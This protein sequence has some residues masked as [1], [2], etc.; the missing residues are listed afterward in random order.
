MAHV[1]LVVAVTAER[2]VLTCG[3]TLSWHAIHCKAEVAVAASIHTAVDAWADE[4][5]GRTVRQDAHG[6]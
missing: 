6:Y 4:C 2:C 5:I 1:K 3:P